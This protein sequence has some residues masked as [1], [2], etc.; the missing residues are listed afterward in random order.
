MK[1]QPYTVQLKKGKNYV[2]CKC[3]ESL[4]QPF[5]DGSHVKSEAEQKSE[6]VIFKAKEDVVVSLC[7]CK[8]SDSAP[9]C[10]GSHLNN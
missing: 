4:N 3:S 2:W 5:C 1:K 9:Y 10:N 6:P 7:G 8:E